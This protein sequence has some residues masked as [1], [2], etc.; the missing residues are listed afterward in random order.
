MEFE[1][2][3]EKLSADERS[4]LLEQG[5]RR[6]F[7]HGD[8]IITEGQPQGALYV[9]LSGRVRVERNLRVRARY[10]AAGGRVAIGRVDAGAE[11]VDQP[12]Q[13][14]RMGKGAIFGEI[15][16]LLEESQA[17]ASVVAEEAAEVVRVDWSMLNGFLD[18]NMELRSRFCQSLAITLARRLRSTN[19]RVNSE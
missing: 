16:L 15:S 2:T 14:A 17:S 19:K 6:T 1:I 7:A 8:V 5:E 9:L 3:F 4:A 13:L 10:V 12:V 11:Y 18:A